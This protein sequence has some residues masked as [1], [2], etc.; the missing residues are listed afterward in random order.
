[1][2]RNWKI[3]IAERWFGSTAIVAR[4]NAP[5][6]RQQA[7][8]GPARQQRE[9]GRRHPHPEH[10]REHDDAGALAE[11]N[12]SLPGDFPS[13]Q[14]QPGDRRHEQL[15]GEV[16]LPVLHDRDH[17]RRRGLEQGC[18]EHPGERERHR[19]HA[20]DPPHGGLQDGAQAA[21]QQD[22]KRQ[23]DRQ[24]GTVA[25]QLGH[26]ALGDGQQPGQLP[27]QAS[28][29]RASHCRASH[30]RTGRHGAGPSTGLHAHDP[31]GSRAA[32][33]SSRTR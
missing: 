24:P 4:P 17:A 2:I 18:G 12:Q 31:P 29:E 26:V 7:R 6:S 33:R 11:R 23:V 9:L 22:G 1:M 13:D 30:W 27:A 16:V 21:D 10:Q 20:G 32:A 3:C 28:H 5:P 14:G 8:P 15:A 25:Q 19:A